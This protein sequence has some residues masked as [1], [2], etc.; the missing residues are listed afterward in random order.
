MAEQAKKE[1]KQFQT[2]KGTFDILPS[3][4]KYWDKVRKSVFKV[5]REYNFERL[6]TPIIEDVELFN[7]GVGEQTDIV[8]KQMFTFR[9]KG[10]DFLALRPENTAAVARAYVQNGLFNLPQPQRLYYFGPF[11]RYEQPQAG[12]YR[13]FHQFGFEIL[14]DAD[15]IYDAQLVQVFLNIAKEMGLEDLLVAVN[16]IGDKNCRPAYKK[17][18]IQYYRNKSNQL[19]KDC[20][21]RLKWN[22]LMS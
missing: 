2:P 21:D 14:G 19:C 12:R 5:A 20:K 4:Q 9:T 17:K 22:I 16:S 10:R 18:L 13:Q 7:I 15:P 11:F 6:D 3:N 8:E 1:K